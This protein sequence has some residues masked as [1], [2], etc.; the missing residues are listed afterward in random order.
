VTPPIPEAAIAR[1]RLFRALDA[2]RRRAR[3]VWVSAPPGSGKTTLVAT[4]LHARKLRATWLRVD[5]GDAEPATFFHYLAAAVRVAAGRRVVLP[6]LTPEFL[7]ALEAF[8]RNYFRALGEALRPGSVIVLDDCHA[9]PPEGSLST[10]L[11]AAVEELPASVTLVL[12]SRGEPPAAL[13]RAQAHGEL[14]LLA[15]P[16]LELTSAE[17]VALARARGSS[18]RRARVEELR[19]AVGGWAAGLSLMLARG[20]GDGPAPIARTFEYFASEVFERIEPAMRR[21]LLEVALLEAPTAELVSRATGDAEAPKVL[22]GLARRGL[23]TVRHDPDRPAFELH[24]LF[25]EFLLQRGAQDLPPGRADE[26]RRAAAAALAAGGPAGAEAAIALLAEARAWPEMARLVAREA[27]GLL[28]QGRARTVARW[29]AALPEPVR[30]AEPWLLHWEGAAV[31]PF[32]P[33]RA[34]ARLRDALERF[35]ARGDAIG[36][37]LSWAAIVESVLFEWKELTVLGPVLAE[38][39][40]LAERFPFPSP[41]VEARI[42]VA[43]FIAA[44]LHLPEHPSYRAW[45]TAVRGL[46]LAAPDPVLRLT[47][48][49]LLVSH[50][51][52]V[53]GIV[54]PNRPVVKALDRI[55]R[56]PATP[57][58]AAVLWLSAVGTHHFTAGELDACAASAAAALDASRRFGLRAW[59]FVSRMLEASVAISRDDADVPERVAAAERAVQPDS[60]IDLANLRV[61]QGFAAL[62]GGRAETAVKLGEEGLARARA[63][64]Y[65]MP[66][67]L[68]LLLL[69]RARV[70]TGDRA[71]AARALGALQEI[72]TSVGSLRARAFAAFVEADLRPDGPERAAALS[73]AFRVVRES[74]APP[75]LLF[76]PGELSELAAAALAHGVP[77]ED[78]RP[79]VRRRGLAPPASLAA[80]ERWPWAV[81]VR[82]LGDFEVVRDEQPWTAGRSGSRK[83]VELLQAL[84]ALGGREVP[85]HPLAEALWPDSEGDARQHALETTVYR[86]R[87]LLGPELVLQR[88]RRIS[89]APSLCGVDVV[90][91]ETRLRASLAELG[92]PGPAAPDRVRAEAAAVVALYRGSL[93]PALDAAWAVDART[94]V[95]R[96]LGRWLSALEEVPGDPGDAGAV[97]RALTQADPELLAADVRRTA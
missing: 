57:A 32:E 56:D 10:V 31:L 16:E 74:G 63:A 76:S 66:A 49:A 75:L 3:A 61:V 21:V 45:A 24:H 14:A 47:A 18:A 12:V 33:A 83:P 28:R 96:M 29:I 93:L 82:V 65:P 39:R 97:R 62:R 72:A 41:E 34:R 4:W 71:G 5:P 50:E 78:V 17:S 85:E 35:E 94:R 55:A 52:L 80:P 11:R 7:P 9:V 27:A 67:V 6:A 86:L 51:A 46:A 38:H 77:E 81:R 36:V 25:R 64:G 87:R 20:D 44:S 43:A 89:L 42:T 95:R 69:A 30:A 68:A 88:Q 13:A 1:H 59:D 60:Q 15:A 79:F 91:L 26:V 40:R 37:W 48:G 2:L 90:H 19:K 23:F 73:T 54:E 8:V 58:P 92:R 22:A 53:L 84:A 70:R